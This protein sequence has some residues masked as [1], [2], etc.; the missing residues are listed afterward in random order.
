VGAVVVDRVEPACDPTHNHA[1]GPD[2][3]KGAELTVTQ[4]AQ[5]AD[6]NGGD[7]AFIARRVGGFRVHG[8]RAYRAIN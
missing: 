3:G 1:V 4:I 7:T 8:G 5:V 6:V 2:I